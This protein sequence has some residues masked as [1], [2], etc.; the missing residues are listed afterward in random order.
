MSS[1]EA[2]RVQLASAAWDD[3]DM[4]RL[5]VAQQAQL[6]ARY[7]GVAETGN[8][9][10]AHLVLLDSGYLDERIWFLQAQFDDGTVYVLQVP[11][12]FTQAQV[13]EFAE[14]VTYHP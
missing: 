6:R 13:V 11:D 7:D 3:A 12:A 4:R 9:R 1:I 2:S 5:T 8:D 14:Q 10:P